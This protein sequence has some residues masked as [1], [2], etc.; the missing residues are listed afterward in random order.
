MNILYKSTRNDELRVSAAQAIAQGISTEGGL[1]VP[2]TV[3][4]IGNMLEEIAKLDYMGRAKKILG[5]YRVY[6]LIVVGGG[7]I[8]QALVN[9]TSFEKRGFGDQSGRY[10]CMQSNW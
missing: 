4:F 3:P 7:N 5:L 2:E 9:Y 6:N 10:P 1:F 8:G